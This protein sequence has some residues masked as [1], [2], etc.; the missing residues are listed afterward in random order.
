MLVVD[1]DEEDVFIYND[2]NNGRFCNITFVGLAVH[3]MHIYNTRLG[4]CCIPSS[5]EEL[6]K[7]YCYLS[8]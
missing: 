7:C 3:N 2:R 8:L 5:F 1:W 6:L 4:L